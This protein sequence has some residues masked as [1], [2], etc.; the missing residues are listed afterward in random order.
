MTK[1]TVAFHSLATHAYNSSMGTAYFLSKTKSVHT[2]I[3]A[4]AHLADG[5]YLYEAIKSNVK[6]GRTNFHFIAV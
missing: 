5:E 4:D 1:L 3:E 2:T 6:T